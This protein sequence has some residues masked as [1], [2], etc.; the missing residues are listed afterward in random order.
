MTP[1]RLAE[2][3]SEIKADEVYFKKNSFTNWRGNAWQSMLM[4]SIEVRKE[5][6]K[7]LNEIRSQH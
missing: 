3:E 6:L 1:E 2:I 4:N 7:E 5:L